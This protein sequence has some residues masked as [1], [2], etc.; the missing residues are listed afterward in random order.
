MPPNHY[1]PTTSRTTTTVDAGLKAHFQRVYNNMA[2]GLLVTGLVAYGFASTPALMQMIHG[3]PLKWVVMLAPLGIIF[4]GLTP[5]KL[6]GMQLSTATGLYYLITALMGASLS[7]IFLIYSGESLARVF[8]ITAGMFA[9]TSV[10]GYT[11]KKDLSGMGSLMMMGLI[12]II[13]ASVVNIFLQSAMMMFV[14]SVIGV[15]VFTGLIAWE[16]Q[17]IRE[18]YYAIGNH[19]E[20]RS[21][22]AIMGAL[23]LYINFINLFLMLL[24]LFGSARN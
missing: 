11:T 21:K 18:A 6:Q 4:F 10:F 9:G 1:E 24:R 5:K 15:V 14:T 3:T 16:T 20:M 17:H 7:Y 8:F 2:L 13:I 22:A 12:G 19:V 23:G